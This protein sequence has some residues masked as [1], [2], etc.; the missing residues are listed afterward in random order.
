MTTNSNFFVGTFTALVTPFTSEGGIDW[1]AFRHLLRL[2][3]DSGVAG[4]V[5]AGTTG[6]SATLSDQERVQLLKQAKKVVKNQLKIIVGVGSN[7]TNKSLAYTKDAQENGADGLLINN[8]YYNKPTEKGLY[9]YFASVASATQLP[10]ML[11]NVPS[12][13]GASI[14]IRLIVRL[15]NDFSHICA[16]K[17]AQEDMGRINTLLAQMPTNFH[18]LSG[19]DASALALLAMG[20]KG[21]V[22][23][24]SNTVPEKFAA[25][26][27]AGLAGDFQQ[28]RTLHF[29]LLDLMQLNFAESNPIPV[30][31]CLAM[32]GYIQEHF[33]APLCSL[34]SLQ[35]RADL[36]KALEALGLEV[37]S[38]AFQSNFHALA[39]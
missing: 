19:D 10:I 17:E 20:A 31:T 18:I 37:S 3:L 34:E 28:A 30:K 7:D 2:Q 6:E 4:I 23:V 26:I 1:A 27:H 15:H 5:L 9:A 36:I 38:I 8:P 35:V 39:I 25:L 33:R 22:S 13:T 11:Y 12:R 21:C 14:P 16:L 32:L 24:I 29:A